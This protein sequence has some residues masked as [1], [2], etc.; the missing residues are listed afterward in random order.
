[1]NAPLSSGTLRARPGL[2][3]QFAEVRAQSMALAA[4]LSAEDACAQSMPD[5]SPLKWHLA[6][7]TWFFE[8]F[9][10]EQFE[11]GFEPHHPAFRVLFNSYYNGV[12][13]KHARPDRGLLTRPSLQEVIDRVSA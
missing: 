10:L 4:P 8:T 6:H 5:A 2:A 12:G 13:D 11:V 9:I 1:M 7:S 3:Q